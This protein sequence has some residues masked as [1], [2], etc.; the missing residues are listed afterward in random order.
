MVSLE[1]V[2]GQARPPEAS[3]ALCLRGD[4][5]GR[6]EELVRQLGHSRDAGDWVGSSLSEANPNLAL[7]EEIRDL[8]AEMAEH[9]T[10][11]RFRGVGQHAWRELVRAHPARAGVHPPESNFNADTFPAALIAASMYEPSVASVEQVNRLLA[12]LTQGQL[13]ALVLTAFQVNTGSGEIPK[14]ELALQTIRATA[15]S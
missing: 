4:L 13:D 5:A 10:V 2:I 9:E 8:E 14:S 3:V 6:H 12:V 7:A 1:D 15:P 11:F